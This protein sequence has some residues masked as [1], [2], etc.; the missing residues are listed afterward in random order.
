M[1]G[2]CFQNGEHHMVAY[3]EGGPKRKQVLSACLPWL[4]VVSVSIHHLS[5]VHQFLLI[6][7][8]TFFSIPKCTDDHKFFRNS[9]D[10]WC[11]PEMSASSSVKNRATPE[12]FVCT[13]W[14]LSIELPR[15]YQI[16]QSYWSLFII[17]IHTIGSIYLGKFEFYNYVCLPFFLFSPCFIIHI[18]ETTYK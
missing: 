16:S 1:G 11:Q 12:L 5:S 6:P 3:L 15:L 18:S 2:T 13:L 17:H 14:E 9:L 7:E 8:L 10:L 4:P